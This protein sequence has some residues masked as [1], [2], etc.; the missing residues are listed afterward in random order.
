ML[1]NDWYYILND[2]EEGPVSE[3]ELIDKISQG[4]IS[5]CTPVFRETMTRFTPAFK[6]E[7]FRSYCTANRSSHYQGGHNVKLSGFHTGSACI[8]GIVSRPWIRWWARLFDYLLFAFFCSFILSHFAPDILEAEEIVLGMLVIFGWVFVEALLLSTWGT[9][10]G[11]Y[12]LKISLRDSRNQ[13][14][15]FN[16]AFK[17]SMYV[18]SAGMGIG[19]PILALVTLI[20]GYRTL[21]IQGITKWDEAGNLVVTHEKIGFIRVLLTVGLLG[22]LVITGSF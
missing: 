3:K 4:E 12:L 13:I 21:N 15:S 8:E 22:I 14:L 5:P 20:M 17:R 10:P 6:V 16:K 7:P 1:E 2:R 11:K 18:W 19:Y 9:T